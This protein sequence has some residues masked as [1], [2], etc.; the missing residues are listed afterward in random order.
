MNPPDGKRPGRLSPMVS[1]LSS[2][3]RTSF[4]RFRSDHD[5]WWPGLCGTKVGEVHAVAEAELLR[6]GS[7]SVRMVFV[8]HFIK[9]KP[10][11][12]P[13]PP[14]DTPSYLLCFF[15]SPSFLYAISCFILLIIFVQ[16]FFGV[17]N[18][19]GLGLL[20]FLKARELLR[21]MPG[22]HFRTSSNL[23]FSF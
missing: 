3:F 10:D 12:P 11:H 16:S 20:T 19:N 7:G 17:K 15:G 1:P 23:F 22:T 14:K 9:E 6:R 8:G 18:P 13:E 21:M 2:T 5:R 4:G